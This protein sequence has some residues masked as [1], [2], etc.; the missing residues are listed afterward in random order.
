VI[1]LIEMIKTI[2]L[3]EINW[4]T[5]LSAIVP[6]LALIYTIYRHRYQERR[7]IKVVVTSSP[8]F[9]E[10]KEAKIVIINEG[11]KVET[12]MRMLYC[13]KEDN[14]IKEYNNC[15]NGKGKF[16]FPVMVPAH[17][18]TSFDSPYLENDENKVKDIIAEDV[19]GKRWYCDKKNFNYAKDLL[20]R[21]QGIAGVLFNKEDKSE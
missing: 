11:N 13:D 17:G 5:I 3:P 9:S 10:K 6:L 18:Y 20:S 16:G 2:Q 1:N 12:I 15:Y 14:K 19:F 4:L 8:R 7:N 21:H